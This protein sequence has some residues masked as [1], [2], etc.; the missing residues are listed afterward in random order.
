[1]ADSGGEEDND[2]V[3]DLLHDAF[4]G[5]DDEGG[6]NTDEGAN[7]SARQMILTLRNYLTIWRSHYFQ[8]VK[9]FQF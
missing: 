6:Y 9:I 7:R 5:S 4:L 1:M 2:D 3:E 8:D